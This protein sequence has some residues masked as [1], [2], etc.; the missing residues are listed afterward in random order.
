MKSLSC[1]NWDI[2]S[3]KICFVL[4]FNFGSC[5][6]SSILVLIE[7]ALMTIW[8]SKNLFIVLLYLK[9]KSWFQHIWLQHLFL[10]SHFS[11]V[12]MKLLFWSW[13]LK[14]SKYFPISKLRTSF[15]DITQMTGYIYKLAKTFLFVFWSF[16]IFK[17]ESILQLGK[18]LN[19]FQ[20]FVF[21]F[22]S[23]M[24]YF[25]FCF[26]EVEQAL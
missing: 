14:S 25:F 4:T 20:V 22:K 11:K 12:K 26:P 18:F 13:E 7:C 21:S 8:Y 6:F 3:G 24:F 16:K 17:L 15:R 2:L 1:G 23:R 19:E 5:G 9:I 10:D